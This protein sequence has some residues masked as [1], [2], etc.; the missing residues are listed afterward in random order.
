[1]DALAKSKPRVSLKLSW[2]HQKLVQFCPNPL[3]YVTIH[4]RHFGLLSANLNPYHDPN[5]N[6]TKPPNFFR[7]DHY[8][9]TPYSRIQVWPSV[10][11]WK[12]EKK[13]HERRVLDCELSERAQ[14]GAAITIREYPDRSMTSRLCLAFCANL[15]FGQLLAL[16]KL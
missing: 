11:Q 10:R 16:R 15:I 9:S 2:I 7:V 8:W 12:K 6:F 13:A 1:M 3:K 14:L 5:Q 4:Y